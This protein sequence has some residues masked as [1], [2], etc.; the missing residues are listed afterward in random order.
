MG[1]NVFPGWF[2]LDMFYSIDL[3]F[4]FTFQRLPYIYGSPLPI[5][6]IH[7]F[8]IF[9]ISLFFPLP[10]QLL[11]LL[12][13]FLQFLFIPIFISVWPLFLRFFFCFYFYSFLSYKFFY[14]FLLPNHLICFSNSD[15]P[16]FFIANHFLNF[17]QLI[18]KY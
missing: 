8:Q 12:Q 2:S 14:I 11:L 5:F 17:F 13:Y 15:S 7:H 1:S 9:P 6:H 10:L 18:S 4:V 3:L 16:C